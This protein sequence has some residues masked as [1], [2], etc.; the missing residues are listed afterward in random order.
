MVVDDSA[1]IRGFLVKILGTC[2]DIEVTCVASNGNIALTNLSKNR[3]DIILLDVEM[4]VMDGLTAIPQLLK[5]QPDVK[6][7]MVSTL[8]TQ[9]A[10]TS[11]RALELGA[12]ECIAKPTSTQ[13]IYSKDT[14]RDT[15]TRII[16][17]IVGAKPQP[18]PRSV[19]NKAQDVA[20]AT[21]RSTPAPSSATPPPSLRSQ[22][23]TAQPAGKPATNLYGRA[24]VLRP[25]QEGFSG[26]PELL[27]IGSSTG[28]PNALFKLLGSLRGIDIPIA[29][30]QH[31]PPTFTKILAEHI[32]QQTGLAA[33]EAE[34]GMPLVAGRV[35]I[36]PGGF[37]MLIDKK[38][39]TPV[40]KI[41]DG[42]MEN[43]CRPAVDPMLRSAVKVFGNRI[44]TVILTGMGQDGMLGCREVAAA[45]GRV[46]A[47]DEATSVVWGMPGA[48]AADGTCTAIL[49]ID[50]IGPWLR[51]SSLRLP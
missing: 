12:V 36:A 4:P 16:R 20:A 21:A 34:D 10:E 45:G 14:F 15:L 13:D 26:K 50:E 1:V 3:H 30:T 40:F 8:T 24:V 38:G 9:N 32:K 23:A 44:M 22:S 42:P 28:G 48:V 47:Q 51:K 25:P 43:F 35:H 39:V 41:D 29:I 33:V 5:I 18:P 11:L 17:E 2:P 19:S 6:I 46:I 7:V 37:H 27:A 49:A 31:M